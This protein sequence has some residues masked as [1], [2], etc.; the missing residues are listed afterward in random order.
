MAR[1]LDENAGKTVELKCNGWKELQR[2]IRRLL[3]GAS[4]G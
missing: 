3:S 2:S 1:R 4:F